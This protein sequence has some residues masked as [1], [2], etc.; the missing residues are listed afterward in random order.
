MAKLEGKTLSNSLNSLKSFHR[1][2]DFE[3]SE[4]DVGIKAISKSDKKVIFDKHVPV[5]V[6]FNKDR[7]SITIVWQEAG[8]KNYRSKQL[9]ERYD[10]N[11]NE[12]IIDEDN[13][14]LEINSTESDKILII[15]Y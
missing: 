5:R 12:M 11:F 10:P 6:V 3:C 1:F 8:I 15:N 7:Q 9:F 4:F 13:F 2:H 14:S